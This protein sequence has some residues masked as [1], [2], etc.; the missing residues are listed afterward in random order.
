M[1]SNLVV[2]PVVDQAGFAPVFLVSALLYPAAWLILAAGR[3][4]P[5]PLPRKEPHERTN[6]GNPA[7]PALASSAWAITS[8]GISSPGCSMN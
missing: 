2:G 5:C 7:P 3:R 4:A 6:G 1:L 8:I